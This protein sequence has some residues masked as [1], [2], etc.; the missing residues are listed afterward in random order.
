MALTPL[1]FQKKPQSGGGS[2]GQVI[3]GA[4][5]GIGGFLVGG[6]AGAAAG[7]SLGMGAGGAGGNILSP[8]KGGGQGM[9]L[10]QSAIARRA[11]APNPSQVLE[12]SLA[13]LKDTTPDIQEAYG[14]PLMKAYELS[15]RQKGFA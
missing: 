15:K 6:P 12:Q 13:A 1:T 4:L 8:G 9:Q 5:G 2:I 14:A 11:E 10:Q 3:G 7:A